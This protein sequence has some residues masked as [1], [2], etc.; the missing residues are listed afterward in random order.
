LVDQARELEQ[1]LAAEESLDAAR[2]LEDA[3]PPAPGLAGWQ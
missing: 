1:L 2:F 3:T